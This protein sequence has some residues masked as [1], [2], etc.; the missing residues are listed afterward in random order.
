[1]SQQI[2]VL[3]ITITTLILF[4]INKL[5]Y[6]F[7]SLLMVLALVLTSIIKPEDAFLGFSH[8]AIITVASILV[9]SNAL[10]KTG[11]VDKLVVL[12]NKGPKNTSYKVFI[13]MF[14]TA[15]LSA[16]MNNVGALALIFPI[17]LKIA[18]D[19]KISPSKLLMP[20]AFAS[21]LG[22][23]LTGI[24]TPSN[25][26]ISSYRDLAIGLEY[27]FFDFAKTGLMITL[28]GIIFTSLLGWKLIPHR[29]PSSHDDRFKIEDYLF[30]LLVTDELDQKGVKIKELFINY[31][32]NLNIVSIMR[33]NRQIVS[34]GGN[35]IIF[36]GDILVVKAMPNKIKDAIK[37]TFLELKGADEEKLITERFLKSDD[38]ALVEV[39]LR[40]DSHLIGRTAVETKLRNRYNANL[41]AVSRKGVY[42]IDRLKKFRFNAGDVLLLQA[43][44]SILSDMYAKMRCIP[45]KEE[46]VALNIKEN[47][48][49]QI[50]T[51]SIF[52]ASIIMVMFSIIPV[53]ISFLM[54]ALLLVIL[55]V[56][57]PREFYDSIEWP[58]LI[59]LGSL[60]ALGT[61][62][63]VSGSSDT[64]ASLLSSVANKYDM[65]VII[66]IFMIITII[67]T[68]IINGKASTILMAPIAL[69][70]ASNLNL[71][72]DPLLI[73]I[74]IG[75]ST[76]FITPI[77]H[78][79]NL[80]VMGPGGYKF[81]D[82]WKLGLPLTIIAIVVGVPLIML[83]WS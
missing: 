63:E 43:P 25:L 52:F 56:V 29:E 61:A 21:L 64:I 68:N 81:K 37:K 46:E 69:S 26:I 51:V 54:A 80:I 66:T 11:V 13:L 74:A 73:A 9:I 4:L 7:V 76:S 31:G 3:V 57:S 30:E 58:T 49:E 55:N 28:V 82:Y 18:S 44:K 2:I 75:A 35:R 65:W 16:F 40:N 47:K 39:V 72:I 53:Q 12:V 71:N 79:S 19:N 83:F 5:R 1:M 32:I 8:P 67:L 77:S 45:L 24:G 78:Q 20:V 48:K 6:D 23:T 42:T 36:P 41:V 22:G 62:I 14:V 33:K 27:N 17:A 38:I 70:V 60:F 50:I 10:V 34:P 15:S 59:M